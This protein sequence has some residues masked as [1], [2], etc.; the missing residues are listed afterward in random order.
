MHTLV[1]SMATDPDRATDV[2]THLQNDITAWAKQQPGFVSG[3]WLLSENRDAGMGFVVFVS[4]N[5]ANQ[6]ASGPRRYIHDDTRAWNITGVTV[7]E[8]VASVTR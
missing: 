3:E 1:V 4:A 2:S 7:Y 6:A 5:A 8:T